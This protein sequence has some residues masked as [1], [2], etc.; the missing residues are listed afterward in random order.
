MDSVIYDILNLPLG[1]DES[2]ICMV[3]VDN[4]MTEILELLISKEFDF[5]YVFIR[6]NYESL[7]CGSILDYCIR[8][9]KVSMFKFFVDYFVDH[10]VDNR[11][12]DIKKM[13]YDSIQ[14]IY[15]TDNEELFDYYLN[16]IS[17]TN[18]A[19]HILAKCCEYNSQYEKVKKVLKL[20]LNV[21]DNSEYLGFFIRD[22]SLEIIKLLIEHGLIVNDDLLTISFL[23]NKL[24]LVEFLLNY[25]I[26]PTRETLMGIFKTMNIPIIKL[27]LNNNID[28][29]ILP[30]YY[31][32]THVEFINQL[33]SHGLDRDKL[34][35]Y[36]LQ[37]ID[38][39]EFQ[40]MQHD[41]YMQ[42][43]QKTYAT[44]PTVDFTRSPSPDFSRSPSPDFALS[45][46][47]PNRFSKPPTPDFSL[48]R[49]T[50]FEN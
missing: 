46:Y 22:C 30:N 31:K 8:K 3:A 48:D 21:T 2:F 49:R 5:N 33:E 28:L 32:E 29:S 9:N 26:A 39:D 17:L 50:R 40:K 41:F 19:H 11:V 37:K 38:H 14:K 23:H 45:P 15:Q 10:S 13:S 24:Y 6:N 44:K 12:V 25:G 1:D 18:D 42:N 16:I 43:F 35:H 47:Q 27:L 20:G 34:L 4:N 36:F 7:Y